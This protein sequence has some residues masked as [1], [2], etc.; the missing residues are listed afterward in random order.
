MTRRPSTLGDVSLVRGAGFFL[1]RDAELED[2]PEEVADEE[3]EAAADEEEEAA[4][5]ELP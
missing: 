2:E 3:E 5:A 4:A 1:G